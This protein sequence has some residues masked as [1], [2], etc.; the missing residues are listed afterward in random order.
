MSSVVQSGTNTNAVYHLPPNN[1]YPSHNQPH[2][3]LGVGLITVAA[4]PTNSLPPSLAGSSQQA[5]T[6]YH[7]L[8]QHNPNPAPA[9]QV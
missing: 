6:A 1:M 8:Q 7:G 4:P 2:P 9:Q 5:A 3:G